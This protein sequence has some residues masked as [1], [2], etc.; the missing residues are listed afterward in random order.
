MPW[1]SVRQ[2]NADLP[3]RVREDDAQGH[4]MVQP[5]QGRAEDSI[6]LPNVMPISSP[7]DEESVLTRQRS[8]DEPPVK[9]PDRCQRRGMSCYGPG[10]DLR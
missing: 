5:S 9:D 8:L 7:S 3:R 6:C 10:G 1:T 4:R 2:R